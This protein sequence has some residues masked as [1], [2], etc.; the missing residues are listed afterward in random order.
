[1][2]GVNAKEQKEVDRILKLARRKPPSSGRR[3]RK[4]ALKGC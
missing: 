4:T 3:S 2:N 1:M